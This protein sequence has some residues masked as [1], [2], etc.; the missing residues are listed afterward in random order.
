MSKGSTKGTPARGSGD[1][2]GWLSQP[3]RGVQSNASTDASF[4][5]HLNRVDSKGS[6]QH[7]KA[8]SASSTPSGGRSSDGATHVASATT[9]ILF[10]SSIEATCAQCAASSFSTIAFALGMPATMGATAAARE[11]AS[12]SLD[13]ARTASTSGL[14]EAKGIKG[15]GRSRKKRLMVLAI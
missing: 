5:Q 10:D 2:T 1:A 4:E 11:S 14:Y 3:A 7:G 6:S 9:D 13:A 15:F 8:A 12:P